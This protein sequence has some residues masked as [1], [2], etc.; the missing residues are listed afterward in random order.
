MFT[1]RW[2]PIFDL[3]N[4]NIDPEPIL[5]IRNFLVLNYYKYLLWKFHLI[6]CI[7]IEFVYRVNK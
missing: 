7:E 2:L 4:Q 5:I 6:Y 3:H 1:V